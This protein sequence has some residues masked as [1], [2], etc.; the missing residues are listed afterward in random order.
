L[1]KWPDTVV[2]NGH[3]CVIILI[4]LFFVQNKLKVLDTL[5]MVC[6]NL[7]GRINSVYDCRLG[8]MFLDSKPVTG[9]V[10]VVFLLLCLIT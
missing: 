3:F 10:Q 1:C 9:I 6:Q 5:E 8:R 7:Q 4:F 2:F